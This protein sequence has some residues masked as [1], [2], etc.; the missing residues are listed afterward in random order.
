MTSVAIEPATRSSA[1]AVLELED[2][3]DA[4]DLQERP[5]FSWRFPF[6]PHAQI[7]AIDTECINTPSSRRMAFI[8]MVLRGSSVSTLSQ[9]KGWHSMSFPLFYTEFRVHLVDLLLK[10]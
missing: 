9:Q 8:T 4:R 6:V 7:L 10:I 1:N 3:L 2:G 5:L